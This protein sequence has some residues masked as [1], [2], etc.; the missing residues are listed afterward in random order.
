[1]VPG[2]PLLDISL[3]IFNPES[4]YNCLLLP[5]SAEYLQYTGAD[6]EISCR[7]GDMIYEESVGPTYS[8]FM[9]NCSSFGLVLKTITLSGSVSISSS[10]SPH[11]PC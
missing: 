11:L 3:L 5:S 8:I 4:Q 10:E 2:H 7:G 1:M 9:K 6:P